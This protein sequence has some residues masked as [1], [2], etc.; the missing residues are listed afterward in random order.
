MAGLKFTLNGFKL[1]RVG[2]FLF[3]VSPPAVEDWCEL[4]LD[5]VIIYLW[6]LDS[7]DD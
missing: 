5:D 6:K 2:I 4:P 1:N 3:F 7:I